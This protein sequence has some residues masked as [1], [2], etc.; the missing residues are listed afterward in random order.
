MTP[1]K[2]EELLLLNPDTNRKLRPNRVVNLA[3]VISRGEWR[4]THQPIAVAS[5]GTLLDGQHRLAAIV[6]AGVA[7]PLLLAENA[8]PE[9]FSMIDIGLKRNPSDILHT[10]GYADTANLASGTR[11]YL[12]YRNDV[13]G[14]APWRGNMDSITPQM[15][16]EGLEEHPLLTELGSPTR[17]IAVGVGRYGFRA[18]ILAALTVIAEDSPVFEE[19]REPWIAGLAV[20]AELPPTSPLL[21]WRKWALNPI[22]RA[23]PDVLGTL[24]KAWN[25]WQAGDD[26]ALMKIN[27]GERLVAVAQPAKQRRSRRIS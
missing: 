12:A 24:L 17:A 15:I 13:F 11:L 9:T 4:L 16:L 6:K 18:G 10:A 7:V 2:A 5:D 23:R 27:R 3:N 19:L 20:G 22:R 8:D 25:S 14:P 1:T 26:V 21:A